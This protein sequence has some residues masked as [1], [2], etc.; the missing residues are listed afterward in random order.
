MKLLKNIPTVDMKEKESV[1]ESKELTKIDTM[2]K[3]QIKKIGEEDKKAGM[4]L[5]ETL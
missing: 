1:N 5:D 2:L 4:E 3:N